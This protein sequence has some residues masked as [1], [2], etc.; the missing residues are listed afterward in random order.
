MQLKTIRLFIIMSLDNLVERLAH[1]RLNIVRIGH[2]ARVLPS[3]IDHT[4]DI[5]TRTCDS[6]QIVSDIRKEMDD[7]LSKIQKSKSRNARRAMY[8]LIWDLRRDYKV[9]EKKVVEEVLTNA[10]VTL[11]TLNG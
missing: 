9:R 7:T 2:P 11:S 4:L 6:G 10:Q 3:V 1:H 8:R 5:I